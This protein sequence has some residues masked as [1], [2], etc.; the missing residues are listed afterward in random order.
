MRVKGIFL[1]GD[2]YLRSLLP[3]YSEVSA[4]A[5]PL[6]VSLNWVFSFLSSEKLSSLILQND[7]PHRA[8]SDRRTCKDKKEQGELITLDISLYQ[9]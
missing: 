2:F 4:D 1:G 6:I 7:S 3:R 9:S 8:V 5:F